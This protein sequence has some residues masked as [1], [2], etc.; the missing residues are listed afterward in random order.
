MLLLSFQ[1]A[2]LPFYQASCLRM[3][4]TVVSP[5]DSMS[6]APIPHFIYCEM[7][8]LFRSHASWNAIMLNKVFY[9]SAGGSCAGSTIGKK[10]ETISRVSVY[11][12]KN[13]VL[14][15]PHWK[16]SNIISVP[17]GSWLIPLVNAALSETPCWSLLLA[18]W[19]PS[20]GCS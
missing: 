14:S 16:Q 2:V 19:A 3:V 15:L 12:S 1:K 5:V 4:E 11:S 20:S 6:M 8:F 17:P 10:G 13:T 18:D 7:N 9:K